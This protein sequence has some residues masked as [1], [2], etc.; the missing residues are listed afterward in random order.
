MANNVTP[1]S[2][3]LQI[4]ALIDKITENLSSLTPA[5][6]GRRRTLEAIKTKLQTLK[7]LITPANINAILFGNL[8][9]SN[10]HLT[11]LKNGN[12]TFRGL[13]PT[14]LQK[15]RI[16]IISAMLRVIKDSYF[17]RNNAPV[18][19]NARTT[20]LNNAIKALLQVMT[21]PPEQVINNNELQR[22]N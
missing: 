1:A 15:K 16:H 20:T 9:L 13:L 5:N 2:V 21:A 12:I 17:P 8:N 18:L 11:K 19:T 14:A 6:N 10:N 7:D 22:L 3:R 4:T